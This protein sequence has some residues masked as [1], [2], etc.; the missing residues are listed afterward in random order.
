M[1]A[2][3]YQAKEFRDN[4]GMINLTAGIPMIDLVDAEAPLHRNVD[5]FCLHI[6]PANVADILNLLNLACM[7]ADETLTHYSV[8]GEEPSIYCVDLE[9]NE[10]EI[11][12][13]A[14][15]A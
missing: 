11:N 4:L 12:V 14:I 13:P 3:C 7:K 5:H 1:F 10:I 9:G 15:L 6:T 8:E 2:P